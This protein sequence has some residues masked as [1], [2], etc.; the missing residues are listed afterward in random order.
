MKKEGLMSLAI[1]IVIC[2]VFVGSIYVNADK[3][4]K[5]VKSNKSMDEYMRLDDPA[6][7]PLDIHRYQDN[8][9]PHNVFSNL[10]IYSSTGQT[11]SLAIPYSKA[12][13]SYLSIGNKPTVF[14]NDARGRDKIDILLRDYTT[15]HENGYLKDGYVQV[16]ILPGY[17]LQE[18]IYMTTFDS[19][20]VEMAYREVRKNISSFNGSIVKIYESFPFIVADIPYQNIFDLAEDKY[21]VH[22][23]LDRKCRVCLNESVPIIKPPEEWEKVENYF[24]YKINGSGIKI[25]I[26]DTGIDKTHPDLDDL[27]DDP[28]TVDPKVIA[29][30]CFTDEDHTWDGYGHGTHCGSIAA[31][32]GEASNYTYVGVA[33]QAYLINGKVLTDDGWGYD[34]WIIDGIEW[35]VNNQSADIISM[36]FGSDINGDGMDPLSLVI[37]WA[38]DQGSVCVVAAGNSG[39]GNMFTVGTPAVS[40]KA[41]TVGATTKSDEIVYFSSLGPTSDYR[42]KPDVCAPGVNIVAARANGTSMGSPVNDYYTTASGTSMST[43]HVAGSAA[44]ILQAHSNWDPS[45]VKSALMGN[46]KILSNEHIWEQGAGRIA[47]C[48]STNTTLLIIKPSSSFGILG[49]EDQIITNLSLMNLA[50][51]SATVNISTFTL[52]NWN[53]TN[54]VSTNVSS[55]TVPGNSND[56]ISLT[57]GPIDM[58]ASEGWYEGW[59]NITDQNC[60]RAPYFFG[61]LSSITVSIVDVDNSTHIEGTVALLDYPNMSFVDYIFLDSY[62]SWGPWPYGTFFTEAGNYSLCAQSAGISNESSYLADYTRMFMLEKKVSLPKFSNLNV[63]LSLAEANVSKIPTNSAGKN[64]TTHCYTHYFN[65]D[66]CYNEFWNTTIMNW[67]LGG[68]WFGLDVKVSNLTF[69]SSSYDPSK[70]LS[71]CIGYYASDEIL[72]EV[73]LLNWKYWN[74]SSLP[75]EITYNQ[76]EVAKYNFHYDM[77]ETYPESGLNLMNAFW[78]TWEYM[79]PFQGWGWDVH[80]VFAGITATYYLSPDTGTYWGEYMPTYKGWPWQNLGPIEDWEIGKHYPPPQTSLEK[81][82]TGTRILGD[83][84]F[85]PY[86]PGLSVNY[87]NQTSSYDITLSGD[88]WSNLRSTYD[89]MNSLYD[90]TVVSGSWNEEYDQYGWSGWNVISGE[91]NAGEES[92]A[93]SGDKNW[94]DYNL[95]TYMKILNGSSA[96]IRFRVSDAGFYQLT[97]NPGNDTVELYKYDGN[98]SL[99]ASADIPIEYDTWYLAEV[100]TKGSWIKCIFDSK[101]VISL[102]NATLINGKIGLR[103]YGSHAHFNVLLWRGWWPHWQWYGDMGPRSP[104]PQKDVKPEYYLYVDDVLI[105]NGTLG[106][107]NI[108]E[109]LG[110]WWD[111]ITQ[112]WN[113]DGANALLSLRMP[114][115]ATLSQWATYNISFNLTGSD[116]IISPLFNS[117]SMPLS[118]SA[119]ETIAIKIEYP[120]TI[121]N[122][123]LMY[124]FDNGTTWYNANSNES[125]YIIPCQAKDRLAILINAT[126]VHGNSYLY[127]SNPVAMCKDVI[128]DAPAKI[129]GGEGETV[130]ISGRLTTIEGNGLPFTAVSLHD[131]DKSLITGTDITGTFSFNY[132][133]SFPDDCAQKIITITSPSVGLFAGQERNI[134][135]IK[136]APP[137]IIDNTPSIAYTGDS[138]IFNATV[139]DYDGISSAWVEYWYGTGSHVNLSM[140]DISDNYWEKNITIENTLDA[141]HYIISANDSSNNWNNTDQKDVTIFDND[142]PEISNVEDYPDVQEVG[143]WVNITCTVTDNVGVDKVYVDISG[144]PGFTPINIT[145]TRVTDANS[146]YYNI[147]YSILGAYYYYIWANDTSNNQNISDI[148]TFTIRDTT[149]PEILEIQ[150]MPDP[151]EVYGWVNITCTVT[152]NVGV[153]VVKVNITYPNGMTA[154]ITMMNVGTNSYSYNTSYSVLGNYS[155]YVWADDIRGNENKSATYT[156]SIRDNTKLAIT[157]VQAVPTSQTAGDYVNITCTVTDNVE[158]NF[159]KVSITDPNGGSVNVSMIKITG[160]NNYYYNSIYPISGEYHYYI[161]ARDASNNQNISAVYTFEIYI[162]NQPPTAAAL[163]TPTGITANSILLSW[164]QNMDEDFDRYEIYQSTSSGVFG[165]LIHTETTKTVTSYTVTGLTSSAT[166]YFTVRV[167]NTGN[168]HA[169]SNQVSGTT[170]SGLKKE[171]PG[172]IPGFEVTALITAVGICILLLRKQHYSQ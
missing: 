47:L 77:P 19:N 86:L 40:R 146:Y 10:D 136:N 167:V 83:F 60:I 108:D 98:Y 142:K 76:S 141:V 129:Y 109:S 61:A 160:T 49:L 43:P 72:S 144:P 119:D 126:D 127:I 28:S 34:S 27:D 75:S 152:D 85:A 138:F 36:S 90:W 159:V 172:I 57:V 135:V 67:T 15:L 149:K 4:G 120:S 23:F 54:Y 16:L 79:G 161:W 2:V 113:V 164:S 37:D 122:P 84:Q 51:T 124:S 103:V 9:H 100:I 63:T 140:S 53:E 156:F 117:I 92:L 65:G 139:I 3:E 147:S 38:T 25:A 8:M 107:I 22:I 20:K 95:H 30:K 56:S 169:D 33:P 71:E 39:Y 97:I 91:S 12:M 125:G 11:E 121:S 111:N 81:G 74:I 104:Y 6:K 78:F 143:G 68:G 133:A 35:A 151:Q 7:N 131:G 5:N 41:V 59:L 55:V 112:S 94:S 13:L 58:D 154:N 32:T 44:L 132:T 18:G 170:S 150:D 162:P 62:E 93:Y 45:M 42:L 24:G 134:T 114:S 66:P 171:K 89:S 50:D 165:I 101:S 80:S 99:I 153:N 155:Y 118:Y 168:L 110:V 46:A 1:V 163:N 88:I 29:E 123:S 87:T 64:L 52:C 116:M 69:Y 73:Y 17:E 70:N 26:L 148:A 106:R 21:V 82:E 157:N 166:Y 14:V 158:V 128:I 31:G 130:N 96:S 102:N 105:A 48:N 115:F 145:M 137:E